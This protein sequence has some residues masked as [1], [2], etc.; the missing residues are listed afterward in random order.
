MRLKKD[1][2]V[3]VYCDNRTKHAQL[4]RKIQQGLCF[5]RKSSVSNIASRK[6]GLINAALIYVFLLL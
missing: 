6:C 4:H 5:E 3:T 1:K 2:I